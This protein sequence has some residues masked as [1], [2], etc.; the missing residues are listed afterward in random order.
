MARF[1]V[2]VNVPDL[3]ESIEFYSTL[4]GVAPDVVKP[5][6]AKWMLEDPRVN[7]AVGTGSL[8][9]GI[10]HLGVQVEDEEQLEEAHRRLTGTGGKVLVEDHAHCCYAI[11]DKSWVTDPSGILWESF[12]TLEGATL[13]VNNSQSPET[14]DVEEPLCSG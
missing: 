13:Y 3:D 2:H 9:I 11:S 10:A 1:H 12:L 4:F 7:F 14:Q 8:P 6:Y 5:N